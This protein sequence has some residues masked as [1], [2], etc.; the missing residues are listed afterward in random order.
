MDY[1]ISEKFLSKIILFIIYIMVLRNKYIRKDK[2][3][4]KIQT[5]NRLFL[6]E[7]FILICIIIAVNIGK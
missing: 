7:F 6:V 3:L 4:P 1:F 5:T 2:V